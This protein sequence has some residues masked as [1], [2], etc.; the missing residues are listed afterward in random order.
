MRRAYQKNYQLPTWIP[1]AASAEALQLVFDREELVR[2]L[3]DGVHQI[4]TEVGRLFAIKLL[5]EEVKHLCGKSHQRFKSRQG[6][7][8]GRQRGVITIAG[9]KVAIPRPRVRSGGEEMALQSYGWLQREEAMPEAVLRRMV[10]GVSCRDYEG[11][12]DLAREGFGVQRSSVSRAFIRASAREV[13]DLA[14]RRFEGIRFPVIFIDGV[15]YQ[16]QM[17]IVVMGIQSDGQKRVLGFRQ[18]GTENSTVVCALLEEL[19]ERGLCREQATLFVLDGSKA[20][21]KAVVDLWGEYAVIQRC[22]VHKKQN[23]LAH[24]PEQ[25]REEVSRRLSRAWSESNYDKALHSMKTTVRW[26]RNINPDAAAS[27]QEG[28]EETLTVIRLKV[29]PQLAVHLR[30]TNPIESCFDGVRKLTRRVKRWRD[31]NMRRR[32]C[33]AG[34]VQAEGRFRRLK[35]YKHLSSLLRALDSII[36]EKIKSSKVA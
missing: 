2:V 9:Q 30:S 33:A 7:R 21:R 10:R 34:L 22:Q 6:S 12:V 1:K 16:E 14:E 25:H 15:D 29:N 27:L 23:V 24:V 36:E 3:Q 17:M 18:G 8:H 31:G 28:M 20:L 13:Q 32:W 5:E 11:V 19:C 26:L 4:G 35:G